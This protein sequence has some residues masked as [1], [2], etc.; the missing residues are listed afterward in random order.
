MMTNTDFLNPEAIATF[1][2]Q[3]FLRVDGILSG[4]ERKLLG[5]VYDRAFDP[6]YQNPDLDRKNLGGTVAGRQILPQVLNPS[7]VFPDLR[8]A[9]FQARLLALARTLLGGDVVRYNDHMILKPG[10][11][12]AATPWHQDQAYHPPTHRYRNVNVWMPLEDASL[13]N[14]C[15]H[16]VPGSHRSVVLPHHVV[17]TA[18]GTALCALGQEYWNLN[19]V[20]VPCP[21]G[22]ATLHHSYML[23]YAGPNPTPVPR[24]AYI[25]VFRAPRRASDT[26]AGF[27]LGG[28]RMS[29]P[30]PSEMI[31]SGINRLLAVPV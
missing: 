17:E 18:Q 4:P 30:R 28:K 27:P 29:P 22:S 11:Y 24:R 1:H 21:A 9:P 13:Q 20:A 12:G 10:G 31:Q 15:L 7:A 5:E 16:F 6:G 2:E 14:G 23:H 26:S 19:S 25:V 3:G 8:V